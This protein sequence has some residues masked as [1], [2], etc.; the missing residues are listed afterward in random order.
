MV[1]LALA[2]TA[3]AQQDV[4]ALFNIELSTDREG[5]CQSIGQDRLNEIVRDCR[6]LALTGLQLMD[7]A[8]PTNINPEAKRLVDAFFQGNT[9]ADRLQIASRLLSS[10]D[11]TYPG[12]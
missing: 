8:Q 6:T 2:G 12:D 11:S 3:L 7:D 1:L 10:C 9:L 5:G 4:T